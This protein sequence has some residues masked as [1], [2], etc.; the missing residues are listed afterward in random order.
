MCTC[1]SYCY[2]SSVGIAT[3]G[4]WAGGSGFDSRQRQVIFSTASRQ[5]PE[6]LPMGTREFFGGDKAVGE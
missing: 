4:L 1:S 5:I 3:D 2:D 6:A